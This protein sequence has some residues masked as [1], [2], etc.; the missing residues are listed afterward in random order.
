MGVGLVSKI[1]TSKCLLIL[2]LIYVIIDYDSSSE[3]KNKK[4]KMPSKR[5][6]LARRATGILIIRVAELKNVSIFIF[7]FYILLNFTIGIEPGRACN[8]LLRS[9]RS[10]FRRWAGKILN[11]TDW[12]KSLDPAL[13]AAQQEQ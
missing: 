1:L 4:V 2:F 3:K 11:N 10:Y 13:E 6:G 8:D 5:L 9:G 7:F 12:P